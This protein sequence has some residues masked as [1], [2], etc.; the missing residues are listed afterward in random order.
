MPSVGFWSEE[1]IDTVPDFALV[2]Q[3]DVT[4]FLELAAA[5]DLPAP[6]KMFVVAPNGYGLEEI[7]ALYVLSQYVGWDPAALETNMPDYAT[8]YGAWLN[9]VRSLEG[10]DVS[11]ATLCIREFSRL[12]VAEQSRASKLVHVLE[13]YVDLCIRP[14]ADI[15]L[16]RAYHSTQSVAWWLTPSSYGSSLSSF[17][18]AVAL[19]LT[20]MPELGALDAAAERASKQ[21]SALAGR[22][23]EDK[24]FDLSAFCFGLAERY[25]A[26]KHFQWSFLLA[27]RSLDLYFQHVALKEGVIIEKSTELGY[28]NSLDK[29]Y[30]VDLEYALFQ[31]E[32]LVPS[33]SRR[34]FLVL[35][36]G[37]RN[38]LL[39]TH[40]AHHV[41]E[42]EAQTVLKDTEGLVVGIEASTK[43]KQRSAALFPSVKGALKVLFE[44]VP[45]IHT[46]VEDRTALIHKAT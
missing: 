29:L 43:W 34:A 13:Q 3:S 19:G 46:F 40:G 39:M 36:N 17:R 11:A 44:S 26:L 1:T 10:I 42:Q 4:T 12:A 18:K 6:Q 37:L 8:R 15:Q 21:W 45:D 7:L 41:N 24:F 33:E 32:V 22:P 5:G 20:E 2:R 35:V 38:N 31:A 9:L 16:F 14:L 28:P 23:T 30:L 27:Y 25:C